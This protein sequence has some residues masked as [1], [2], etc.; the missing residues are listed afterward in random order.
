LAG[1]D[2]INLNN[3]NT[4]TGLTSITVNGGDPTAGSDTLIV[5]GIAGASDKFVVEPSA[6]GAGK[7]R[8]VTNGF[9]NPLAPPVDYS[10][11]E[12]LRI[13]GQ[14][15]DGDSL[16]DAGTTGDDTFEL[17]GGPD[18]ASGVMNGFA[19]GGSGFAFTPISYSG[20][21]QFV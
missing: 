21:G 4:P 9:G 5:N 12:T 2:T 16:A 8:D 6:A 15:G 14:T 20:I 11:V 18:P 10:G 7:V 1:S 3:P 17:S 13:A 19:Q